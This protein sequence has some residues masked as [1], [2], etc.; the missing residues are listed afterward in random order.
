MSRRLSFPVGTITRFDFVC[1]P[2]EPQSAVQA[3]GSQRS[4][5]GV[6]ACLDKRLPEGIRHRRSYV[7][8]LATQ[9]GRRA[10]VGRCWQHERGG[11][12]RFVRDHDTGP[13]ATQGTQGAYA[14]A[15]GVMVKDEYADIGR[16]DESIFRTDST[17]AQT[18]DIDVEVG[19]VFDQQDAVVC[20]VIRD[21]VLSGRC[22]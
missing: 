20:Q 22:R 4:C 13:R 17:N 3:E 6:D 11:H 8:D 16:S 7:I 9:A 14:E 5:L 19:W 15:D 12:V 2:C 21:V 10:P 1:H 18:A